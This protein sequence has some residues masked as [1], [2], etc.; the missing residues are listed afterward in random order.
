MK[1]CLICRGS[2]MEL[3]GLCPDC[4]K[5]W[6]DSINSK[7]AVDIATLHLAEDAER[8]INSYEAES[9]E[10]GSVLNEFV[11][12]INII[13]GL[14]AVQNYILSKSIAT[15]QFLVKVLQGVLEFYPFPRVMLIHL[16]DY[17]ELSRELQTS[18]PVLQQMM[19]EY[20]ADLKKELQKAITKKQTAVKLKRKQ[21][22]LRAELILLTALTI[23]ALLSA[24]YFYIS[25]SAPSSCLIV[26]AVV[27]VLLLFVMKVTRYADLDMNLRTNPHLSYQID[28]MD[29]PDTYI[30]NIRSQLAR[31]GAVD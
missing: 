14:N 3:N 17:P 10:L 9:S 28:L 2:T 20:V 13:Q 16:A 6:I 12:K 18:S 24:L 29:I 4:G 31:L 11:E 8:I 1:K 30:Q 27:P 23:F 15:Y 26:L 5:R 21:K 25:E 7:T 22:I 19:T